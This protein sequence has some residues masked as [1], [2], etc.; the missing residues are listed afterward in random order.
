MRFRVPKL[1]WHS[2]RRCETGTYAWNPKTEKVE[3][4]S[5]RVSPSK[6]TIFG[7]KKKHAGKYNVG[8]NEVVQSKE[9]YRQILKAKGLRQADK[10][11]GGK[12][13]GR[14]RSKEEIR[15]EVERSLRDA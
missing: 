1:P 10:N 2:G 6:T 12:I 14:K 9:H 15:K 13:S 7:W 4:I 11:E 8:L 3:K 5:D